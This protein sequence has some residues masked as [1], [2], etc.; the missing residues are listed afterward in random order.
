[1]RLS[2]KVNMLSLIPP[3]TPTLTLI[4]RCG[5]EIECEKSHPHTHV[6]ISHICHPYFHGILFRES[7]TRHFFP[8]FHRYAFQPPLPTLDVQPYTMRRLVFLCLLLI[9]ATHCRLSRLPTYDPQLYKQVVAAVAKTEKL[10]IDLRMAD[11]SQR[12][13]HQFSRRYATLESTLQIIYLQYEVRPYNTRFLPI[14]QNIQT[15]FER[16][17]NEHRQQKRAPNNAELIIYQTYLRDAWKPL[18]IAEQALK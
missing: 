4:S 6:K 11:T 5:F 7:H 13:F 14:L 15:L 3:L 17:K 12:K 9:T 8:F 16:Y 2:V 10:Y 1:L 18:L